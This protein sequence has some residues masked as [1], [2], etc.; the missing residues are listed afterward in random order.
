MSKQ[1]LEIAV[2]AFDAFNRRDIDTLLALATPD[3]VLTSQLLDAS[4]EFHGREGLERYYAMLTESWDEFRSVIEEYRDLGDHVLFLV[5]YTA[6]G[7][8]SGVTVDAPTG[9]VLDFR[10]SEIS[11]V[12]LYVDRAEAWRAAGLE[13]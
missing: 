4:A 7:I 11:R 9:A 1:N 10:D 8:G 3:Y 12:R 2:Q 5:R 6:R 13:G